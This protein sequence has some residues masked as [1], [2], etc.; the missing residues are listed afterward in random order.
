MY[1]CSILF[2]FKHKCMSISNILFLDIETAPISN[3]FEMLDKNMQEL[4]KKKS[5][6]W[7]GKGE[8]GQEDI[9]ERIFEEKAGIYAEFAKVICISVGFINDR[10][11]IRK[12]RLNSYFDHDEKKVLSDFSLLLKNYFNNPNKHKLCGHNIK[13]FDIPFLSRRMIINGLPLPKMLDI[14]GKK[15]WETKHLCDTLEMWKF[16]DYK[17]YTSLNLLATVLGIKSPKDDIDGSM[18]GKVYWEDKDLERIKIYC[19]KDVLTV[20]RIYLKM[21]NLPDLTEEEE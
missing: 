21:Q 17:N 4:W 1:I 2:Y 9:Y 5:R 12:I 10:E 3:K 14:A 15:P 20:A 7:I 6:Y 19:E 16:G 18:V 8:E 13:E 11:G